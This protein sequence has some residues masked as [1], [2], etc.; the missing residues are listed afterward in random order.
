[1]I[2]YRILPELD[3]D[4]AG[5]TVVAIDCNPVFDD[6]VNDEEVAEVDVVTVDGE[7][8]VKDDFMLSFNEKQKIGYHY[9]YSI[10]RNK[11]K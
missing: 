3:E 7:A 4:V 5:A 10:F 9:T 11:Q 1:M 2:N 8:V 6:S